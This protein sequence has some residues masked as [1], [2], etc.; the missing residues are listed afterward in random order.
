M[1]T[2]EFT[3]MQW[4][5]LKAQSVWDT[6]IHRVLD[7]AH[8]VEI[9][10]VLKDKRRVAMRPLNLEEFNA[11]DLPSHLTLKVVEAQAPPSGFS[12]SVKPPEAGKPFL[13]RTVIGTPKWVSCFREAYAEHDDQVI[14]QL[15]GYPDCCIKF[16]VKHWVKQDK[17]DLTWEQMNIPQGQPRGVVD[18]LIALNPMFNRVGV[19]PIQHMACNMHCIESNAIAQDYLSLWKAQEREWLEEILSWPVEWSALHGA[20]EIRTPVLKIIHDTNHTKTELVVQFQGKGYPKEG[21]TGNRFPYTGLVD[22]HSNNGFESEDWMRKHHDLILKVVPKASKV[23]SIVDLGCG[24]GILVSKIGA[25]H[26]AANLYGIDVNLHAIMQGRRTFPYIK[27]RQTDFLR[28]H[29]GADMVVLMPG[30]LLE[31]RG[32]TAEKFV[33]S[34]NF[35]YLLLYSYSAYAHKL[36]DL[37]DQHWPNLTLVSVAV[38]D[39]GVAILLEKS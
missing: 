17:K 20:A 23:K 7:E 38:D 16:F 13:L 32:V 22:L 30:R 31:C 39:I 34:L 4:T 2:P 3:R 21:A 11:L 24:N 27:F 19:R 15:L 29:S 12:V 14:G 8:R 35:R 6:R 25:Y 37:K 9:E 33:E 1:N 10:T 18:P 36:W 5:D 26:P 28:T